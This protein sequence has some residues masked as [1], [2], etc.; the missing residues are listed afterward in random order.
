VPTTVW[1]GVCADSSV[2]AGSYTTTITYTA[3]TN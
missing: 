1:Y 3:V 2:P